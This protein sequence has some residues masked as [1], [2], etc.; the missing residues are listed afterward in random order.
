[1]SY[2]VF[3]ASTPLWKSGVFLNIL[4]LYFSLDS[5]PLVSSRNKTKQNSKPTKPTVFYFFVTCFSFPSQPTFP[6]LL[7]HKHNL[8]ICS[9]FINHPPVPEVPIHPSNSSVPSLVRVIIIFLCFSMW[10]TFLSSKSKS[11]SLS[12]DP[13]RIFYS[14]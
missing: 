6:P 5:I 13:P 14:S 12:P 8:V 11:L 2:K 1:M 9:Y 7:F 4:L 10:W 3:F